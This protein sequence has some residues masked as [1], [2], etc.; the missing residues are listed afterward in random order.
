MSCLPERKRSPYKIARPNANSYPFDKSRKNKLSPLTDATDVLNQAFQGL[1]LNSS[2][3][4]TKGKWKGRGNHPLS[5]LKNQ[6]SSHRHI[7]GSNGC[8]D[9]NRNGTASSPINLTDKDDDSDNKSYTLIQRRN[10]SDSGRGEVRGGRGGVRGGRDRGRC[11]DGG[12]IGGRGR[13]IIRCRDKCKGEDIDGGRCEEETIHNTRIS[14]PKKFHEAILS[15]RSRIRSIIVNKLLSRNSNASAPAPLTMISL[16]F[17]DADQLIYEIKSKVPTAKQSFIYR[18]I[19]KV[20]QNASKEGF[21]SW[22]D[23]NATGWKLGSTFDSKSIGYKKTLDAFNKLQDVYKVLASIADKKYG[24]RDL[25]YKN[26]YE[27]CE[28]LK[29]SSH[30]TDMLSSMRALVEHLRF[31]DEALKSK[32]NGSSDN[33]RF[34]VGNNHKYPPHLFPSSSSHQSSSSSQNLHPRR[35]QRWR[36]IIFQCDKLWH[37]SSANGP[38]C[39][40][41]WAAHGS[42]NQYPLTVITEELMKDVIVSF[43]IIIKNLFDF[44]PANDDD[45]IGSIWFNSKRRSSDWAST[46]KKDIC[47]IGFENELQLR[48]ILDQK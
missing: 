3:G 5:N 27:K 44:L 36:N 4:G 48:D 24:I 43:I 39:H 9:N 46:A 35:A 30:L 14:F 33:G 32:H 19:C 38:A 29:K 42:K 45:T 47:L 17:N 22:L 41:H 25:L 31:E 37:S 8:H 28:R 6:R 1:T 34:V 11:S 2:T 23:D 20:A 15:Q 18:D 7:S 40:I 26:E 13:D 12:R 16:R 10:K 21:E